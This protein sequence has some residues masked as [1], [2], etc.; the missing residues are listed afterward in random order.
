MNLFQ[1]FQKRK[2]IKSY[3]NKLPKDL[4]KRYGKSKQYTSAQVE[5]TVREKG[6]NWRHICYAHAMHTS[7][8]HFNAW[9]EERGE[10]NDYSAMLDE[11]SE[12]YFSGNSA[13]FESAFLSESNT[14]GIG[15]DGG[16]S[17]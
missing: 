2:A 4:A 6:Y 8:E 1:Q 16:G 14:D 11:I 7:V 3:I 17:D 13:S 12:N 10:S 5:R 9:H 15:A